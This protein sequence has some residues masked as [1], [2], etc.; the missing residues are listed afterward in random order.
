MSVRRTRLS[1]AAAITALA[2]AACGSGTS[3]PPATTV[4]KPSFPAGT[5]MARLAQAGKITVGTKFDQPGFGLQGLDGRPSGFDVEIAKLIAAS[6]GIPAD[7]ITYVESPARVREEYLEQGKADLMAATYTINARRRERVGFAGPYYIAGQD[8]MVA[9]ADTSITGPESLEA[10]PAA[11]VCSV[12]GSTPA[13]RIRSYLADPAQLVL[14]DVY[15]KCAGAL[16]TGQVRAITSDNVILL[17]LVST[18]QG[19]FKLVGNAFSAEPYGIGI[20]KG[21]TAFCT[22][23]DDV[24]RKAV[25]SGAYEKA[26]NDTAGKVKGSQTPDLPALAHCA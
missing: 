12:T 14:F 4:A 3:S 1:R 21:D 7:K 20:R 22:F 6:L 23:I 9:T 17:G 16:R 5:T 11:K 18:S 24:L 10:R 2:L 13:E 25:A 15:S 8:M 26:W 19:R